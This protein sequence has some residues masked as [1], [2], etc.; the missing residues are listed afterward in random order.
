MSTSALSATET[1][2]FI[3]VP[4]AFGNWR[5]LRTEIPKIPFDFDRKTVRRVGWTFWPFSGGMTVFKF[6]KLADSRSV[7][8]GVASVPRS[9][10]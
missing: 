4:S 6:P 5:K 3:A 1:L 7:F 9:L 2:V 10:S 8:G